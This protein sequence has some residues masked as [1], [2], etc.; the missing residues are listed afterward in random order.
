MITN[1]PKISEKK[2]NEPITKWKKSPGSEP[3]KHG[4]ALLISRE[5]ELGLKAD[6]GHK[7]I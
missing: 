6:R 5:T 3:T 1:I 7:I 4:T 2:K